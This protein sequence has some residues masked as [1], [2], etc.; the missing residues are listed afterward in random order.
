M[1]KE[2]P[3]SLTEIVQPGLSIGRFHETVLGALAV[4]DA[5]VIAFETGARQGVPL[6]SSELPLFAGVYEFNQGR[7]MDVT[8][9]VFRFR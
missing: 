1:R 7:L 8:Q 4:A 3:V 6:G 9:I 5:Q 2:S